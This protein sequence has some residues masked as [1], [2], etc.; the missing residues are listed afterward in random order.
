M[1][2]PRQNAHCDSGFARALAVGPTFIA[3]CLV[4]AGALLPSKALSHPLKLSASLIEYDPRQ[5]TFRVECKVFADDFDHSLFTSVLRG[6]DRSKLTAADKKRAIEDYFESFYSIRVND[7]NVALKLASTE[8]LRRHNV[9]VVRFKE[10]KLPIKR[11]DTLEIRNIMFFKDFGPAQTN[12]ITV[13]IPSFEI[14][15]GHVATMLEYAFTYTLGE[16]RR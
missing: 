11:G 16:S 15:D 7:T 13:R 12:R 9:L 6:V 4:L 1:M 3:L 14:D 2:R 8:M 10:V 5:K